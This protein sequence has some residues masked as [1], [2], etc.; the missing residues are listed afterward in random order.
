MRS[1][2]Q[3]I[4]QFLEKSLDDIQIMKLENYL[5]FENFKTN[6]S[7]NFE[8]LKEAGFLNNEQEFIRSGK[9]GG[10]KDYFTEEMNKE[11]DIWIERNLQ[12]IGIKFP[13]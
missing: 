9:N 12:L 5:K 13:V 3:K 6:R 10:W 4:A 1:T 2:L 7:V 8:A 11:A